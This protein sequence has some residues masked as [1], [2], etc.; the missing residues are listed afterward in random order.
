MKKLIFLTLI[1]SSCVTTK[2]IE[3]ELLI[4]E[5]IESDSLALLD[6]KTTNI[7]TDNKTLK[8]THK[9][10]Y[11]DG[12]IE[13]TIIEAQEEKKEETTTEDNSIISTKDS[14]DIEKKEE[15]KEVKKTKNY[16]TI[17]IYLIVI[18][19]IIL[20]IWKILKWL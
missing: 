17:V 1:L 4:K 12:T 19:I 9:I 20:G 2:N 11:P 8:I 15:I 13:E 18:I 14:Y 16:T 6:V 3:R 5:S 7:L 10:S